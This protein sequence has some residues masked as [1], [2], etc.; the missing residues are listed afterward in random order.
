MVGYNGIHVGESGKSVKRNPN[1]QQWDGAN[2]RS[3]NP[4]IVR[5]WEC[6]SAGD[7]SK[8]GDFEEVVSSN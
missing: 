8:I 4:R 5:L 1:L 2:G 7:L 3:F 6:D